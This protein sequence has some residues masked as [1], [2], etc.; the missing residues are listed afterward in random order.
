MPDPGRD[1]E[2]AAPTGG[3]DAPCRPKRAN[4]RDADQFRAALRAFGNSATGIGEFSAIC[5][6]LLPTWNEQDATQHALVLL[7]SELDQATTR[8]TQD[9]IIQ[10]L[11]DTALAASQET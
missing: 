4:T 8:E 3:P 5:H 9:E 7:L 1:R 6:R 10:R 2:S 11:R